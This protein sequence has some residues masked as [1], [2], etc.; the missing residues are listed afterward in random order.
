MDLLTGATGFLGRALAARLARGGRQLRAL[1]RPGTDLRRIPPEISEIVWGDLSDDD[2]VERAYT[3][4]PDRL[5][6]IDR[7]GRIAHKSGP[8]PYG[9]KPEDVEATLARLLGGGG[10][11]DQG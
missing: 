2:A 8:G 3:G 9:F 4:W 10:Q 6:V 1:V 11:P 7:D 5:Y